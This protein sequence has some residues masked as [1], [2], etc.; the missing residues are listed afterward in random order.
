MYY[1]YIIYI[2]TQL[3]LLQI[4]YTFSQ[5]LFFCKDL[6]FIFLLLLGLLGLDF[7]LPISVGIYRRF[8]TVG[9][10]FLLSEV[11]LLNVLPK[12]I[13]SSWF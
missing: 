8:L 11:F 7:T 12:E 4:Q 13:I 3:Y 6:F 5:W 10:W 9:F 2:Y 1:T